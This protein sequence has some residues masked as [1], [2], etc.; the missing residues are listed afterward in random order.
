MPSKSKAQQRLMAMCEH[1][2]HPRGGCPDMTKA[3]MREFAKTPAKNL[4]E[5]AT[6]KK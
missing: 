2:I 3:Q 5:R 1:G 6:K 4:P